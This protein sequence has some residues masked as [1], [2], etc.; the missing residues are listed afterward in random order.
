LPHGVI[1]VHDDVMQL[2]AFVAQLRRD[3]EA[4]AEGGGPEVA[5]AA[6]RLVRAL[7]AAVRLVLLDALGS[8]VAEINAALAARTEDLGAVVTADLRLRGRDP[9][10]VLD[11][12]PLP[13]EGS[14]D[15]EP[16]RVD[17]SSQSFEV[18]DDGNV[19]RVTLR[20]PE[21]LKSMVDSAA[22]IAGTSLNSYISRTL[23]EALRT[24]LPAGPVPPAGP[25]SRARKSGTRVKGWVR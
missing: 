15:S 20:L 10:L 6:A 21:G 18:D 14:S 9:E 4:A 19:T 16:T 13:A 2:D 23:S 1:V 12:V 5:E 24:G 22:G 3:L 17:L 11:V 8:G 25:G 7:E